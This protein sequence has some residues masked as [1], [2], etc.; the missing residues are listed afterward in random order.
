MLSL[1][2]YQLLRYLF[3][4]ECC[5]FVWFYVH[6]AHGMQEIW[7]M[8][9]E[10]NIALQEKNEV[11]VAVAKLESER[12]SWDT[13]TLAKERIARETLNMARPLDTVYYWS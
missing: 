8:Q 7:R 12:A 4:G 13:K 10:N 1:M 5:L 6:G 3:V 11:E 2:R 9:K